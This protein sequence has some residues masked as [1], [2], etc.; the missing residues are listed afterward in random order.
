MHLLANLLLPPS[1]PPSCIF[2]DLCA[3]LLPLLSPSI[4]RGL[5]DVDDDVRAVAASSLLPVADQLASIMPGQVHD[6]S[7]HIT[8]HTSHVTIP[9]SHIIHVH[10]LVFLSFTQFTHTHTHTH[11]IPSLTHHT[12]PQIPQLLSILWNSLTDLDDLSASTSSILGLLC[13][14]LTQNPKLYS[15]N[16]LRDSEAT[17]YNNT[18]I[19]SALSC[20]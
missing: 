9:P 1:L 19:T 18:N 16:E 12:P 15:G 7:S 11:H 13:T 10:I 17:V 6:P 3:T 14:L 8:H 5:Q 4:L 2:Q 20:F